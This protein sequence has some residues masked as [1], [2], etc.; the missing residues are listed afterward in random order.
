MLRE[1]S[2]RID[3]SVSNSAPHHTEIDNEY[4]RIRNS[5]EVLAIH[6]THSVVWINYTNHIWQ[7]H[8]SL[9]ISLSKGVEVLEIIRAEHLSVAKRTES[10]CVSKGL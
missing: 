7:F 2:H 9:L 6:P 1:A 8:G 3:F 10:T 5:Q 4:F